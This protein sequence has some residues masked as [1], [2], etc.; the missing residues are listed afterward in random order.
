MKDIK[1]W[2]VRS[3]SA[4]LRD[5]ESRENPSRALVRAKMSTGW[6]NALDSEAAL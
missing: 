3:V 6:R 2:C 1:Y 4:M 5:G